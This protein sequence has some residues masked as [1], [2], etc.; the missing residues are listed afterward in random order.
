MPQ[1]EL[2]GLQRYLPLPRRVVGRDGL[3]VLGFRRQCRVV[4]PPLQ[5]GQLEVVHGSMF[6]GKTE[7]MIARLRAAQSVGQ[8]VLAFKHCIDDRYVLDAIVT[9]PG[10]RFDAVRVPDSA[11][12]MT[13]MSGG[14]FLA[15]DEG[16]FFGTTLIEVVESLRTVGKAVLVAGITNDA[17]GR[18]FEPMPQLCAMAD[19][20]VVKQAPC[21]V[22]GKPAPFT[23][24]MSDVNT[25]HMVGGLNDYEPRCELHFTPL[26]TPPEVR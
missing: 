17:W 9:H 16:H 1:R 15:I 20:V 11:S 19:S 4:L 12:I 14:D 22:C 8:R 5:P 25:Q 23:Q 6:G 13:H 21:R 24:R 2:L 7:H 18:P 10:E 3:P 26:A